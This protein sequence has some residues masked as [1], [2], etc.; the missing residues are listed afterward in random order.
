MDWI[1]IAKK[2]NTQV[3]DHTPFTSCQF[4]PIWSEG[5]TVYRQ[6]GAGNYI[7]DDYRPY[8]DVP[9]S[10][11]MGLGNKI[12]S[13]DIKVCNKDTAGTNALFTATFTNWNHG[14]CSTSIEGSLKPNEFVEL[15]ISRECKSMDAGNELKLMIANHNENANDDVCLEDIYLR[16][17]AGTDGTQLW[18]CTID[19]N[20]HFAMD[21]QG[22]NTGLPLVCAP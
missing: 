7:D 19:G 4:T 10:C 21:F 11:E 12:M 8:R 9:I 17:A 13:M 3:T 5:N 6:D 14:T 2:K 15:E 18:Q 16:V 1:F 20:A 22:E